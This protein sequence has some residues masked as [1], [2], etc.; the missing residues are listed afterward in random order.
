[1]NYKL[2]NKLKRRKLEM[3]NEQKNQREALMQTY[4]QVSAEL[5]DIAF[6]FRRLKAQELQAEAKQEKAAQALQEFDNQPKMTPAPNIE[7]NQ[8][9]S[10]TVQLTEVLSAAS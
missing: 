10:Q 5:G 7:T 9:V 2:S 4:L 1:M 3:A 6:Q 8:E